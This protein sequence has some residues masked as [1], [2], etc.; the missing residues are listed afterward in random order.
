MIT[1]IENQKVFH[2]LSIAIPLISVIQRHQNLQKSSRTENQDGGRHQW[3]A[4][5]KVWTDY[6]A[7]E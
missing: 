2:L 3:E 7:T 4:P 1:T 5:D 6:Q